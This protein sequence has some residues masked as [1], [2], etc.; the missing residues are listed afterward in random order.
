[1]LRLVIIRKKR[2]YTIIVAAIILFIIGMVLIKMRSDYVE[3]III[4][5][6]TRV[7]SVGITMHCHFIS[8]PKSDQC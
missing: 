6:N 4:P 5:E 1:M 7:I 2:M 8:S 3:T